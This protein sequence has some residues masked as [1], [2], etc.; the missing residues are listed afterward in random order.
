MYV[1]AWAT[2]IKTIC[3][4]IDVFFDRNLSKI[5]TAKKRVFLLHL[6]LWQILKINFSRKSLILALSVL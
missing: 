4:E 3:Y 5:N 6:N 2:V 1:D